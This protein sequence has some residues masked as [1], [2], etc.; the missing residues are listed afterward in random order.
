[1]IKTCLTAAAIALI[2]PFGAG[3]AVSAQTTEAVETMPVLTLEASQTVMKAA[4]A[5]AAKNGASSIVIVDVSGAPLLL[6]RM[7]G[8]FPASAAIAQGKA[9]TAVDFRTS[10]AKMEAGING[11]R[12]ALL[13]SGYVMMEGGV[14][15]LLDG[16]VVGAVGVSGGTKEQDN[17]VA[18]A[19]AAALDD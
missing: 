5:E 17:A 7:T 11:P 6:H 1:M 10:T 18:T 19:G 14:P 8:A 12:Q 13:S 4:E 9:R 2:T 3:G 15:L 16:H